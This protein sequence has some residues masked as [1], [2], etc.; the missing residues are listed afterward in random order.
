MS[1]GVKGLPG[2]LKVLLCRILWGEGMLGPMGVDYRSRMSS[3]GDLPASCVVLSVVL[4]VLIWHS[5]NSLDQ[6]KWGKRGDMVYVVVS[7]ELGKL[8]RCEGG[9]YWCK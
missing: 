5:M 1:K 9:H 2:H 3:L 8:I 6:G 7:Q 4:M